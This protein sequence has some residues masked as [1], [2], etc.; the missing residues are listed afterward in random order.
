M[1]TYMGMG[2]KAL[3]DHDVVLVEINYRLGPLG[4]MCIDHPEAAG[5]MGLMD[6]ALALDW[7]RDHIQDFGGN[8][9]EITIFGESA[10][11]ASVSYHML[12]PMTMNKFQR[13][14]AQSGSALVGWAFDN[15]PAEHA[16]Q[17][18]K[19][20]G[21]PSEELDE[22]VQCMKYEKSAEDIVNVHSEYIVSSKYIFNTCSKY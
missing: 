16:R 14:I 21:C 3:L 20:L 22:L 4:F 12:S 5:N 15:E 17:M 10:G 11:A 9:D 13:A 18:A 1:G 2:P 7:V 19:K 6:Q 8:P